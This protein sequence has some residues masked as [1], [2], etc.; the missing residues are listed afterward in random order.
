MLCCWM[1][2]I[3]I[4]KCN[5]LCT[6]LFHIAVSYIIDWCM[7]YV[8]CGVH[9]CNNFY[10]RQPTDVWK[11]WTEFSIFASSVH[12]LRFEVCVHVILALWCLHFTEGS[13]RSE[14]MHLHA[15]WKRRKLTWR[16]QRRNKN[17]EI[18]KIAW[19]GV[20]PVWLISCMHVSK[21]LHSRPVFRCFNWRHKC[22]AV[23]ACSEN[24]IFNVC[25]ATVQVCIDKSATDCRWM[26]ATTTA[27]FSKWFQF[28]ATTAWIHA[29]RLCCIY[30]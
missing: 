4:V 24:L 29:G 27:R 25:N 2:V 11:T 28:T 7:K 14:W 9:I 22:L 1:S 8:K 16:E 10:S 12:D 18:G 5:N 13:F 30:F 26:D 17:G 19:E 15:F 20:W 21:S 23:A 6:L 3:S